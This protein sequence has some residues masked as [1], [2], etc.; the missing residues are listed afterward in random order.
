MLYLVD[1]ALDPMGY[2]KP[3]S[4]NLADLELAWYC[5]T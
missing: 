5:P 3:T 4:E 2:V 1:E